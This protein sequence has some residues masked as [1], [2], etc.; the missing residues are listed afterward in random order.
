MTAPTLFDRRPIIAAIAGPNGAGKTTFFQAHLATTGLPFINADMLAI[1]FAIEPYRAAQL[2]D[3]L[4]R[5]MIARRESFVFETVF[6]DPAGDKIAFLKQAER[7]GYVVVL[8]FIGLTDWEQS[9]QRVSI[10]LSQGGHDVPDEKL[11]ARFPRTIANLRSALVGLPH[12]LVYDNSVLAQPYRQV[13]VFEG[14]HPV[15]LVEPIPNW[16]QRAIP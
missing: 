1:E 5:T 6:S 7:D 11:Q 3:A 13:A 12:V 9:R 10:R 14:G 2:A 16:L 8:C 15:T 4:R